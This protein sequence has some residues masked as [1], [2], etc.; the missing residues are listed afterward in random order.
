MKI[1]T[2]W[3][4]NGKSVQIPLCP[5]SFFNDDDLSLTVDW[6]DG[7]SSETITSFSSSDQI[8]DSN[9]TVVANLLKHTYNNGNG[10]K[11]ITITGGYDNKIAFMQTTKQNSS[12]QTFNAIARGTRKFFR[13]I[14]ECNVGTQFYI[15]G[16]GDFRGFTRLQTLG[17]NIESLTSTDP[18]SSISLSTASTATM[19]MDKTFFGCDGLQFFGKFE[20][21]NAT[22]MQFTLCK[23]KR[24][25]KCKAINN[26][27]MEKV[28]SCKGACKEAA[29]SVGLW[30]WFKDTPDKEYVCEDMSGMFE[31]SSFDKGVNG[32]D[33]STVKDV[34]NM[35]KESNFNKPLWKW[36]KGDNVV[37]NVSG[38]F[39]DN[40]SFNRNLDTWDR[41]NVSG[42]LNMF[43]GASGMSESKKPADV[44]V[45][46]TPTPSPS[47]S[48]ATSPT[49]TPSRTP[50]SETP[51]GFST[52]LDVYLDDDFYETLTYNF[53]TSRW[54]GSVLYLRGT[55]GNPMEWQLRRV[56]DNYKLRSSDT[57]SQTNRDDPQGSDF[58]PNWS[59]PAPSVTP[60]ATAS[61]SAPAPTATPTSSLTPG[62]TP[63][64]S[65]PAP[66]ATPTSSLTP[67]PTP[68]QSAPAPTATPTSS[69][70]PGPTPS[71]SAPAPS[72]TPTSSLTPGP[73]ATLTPSVSSSPPNAY[74]FDQIGKVY[75]NNSVA[76][77][78]S[79]N[80][81]TKVLS[82]DTTGNGSSDTTVTATIDTNEKY[83]L[84]SSRDYVAI[85]KTTPSQIFKMKVTEVSYS[86]SSNTTYYKMYNSDYQDY[87][88]GG[89]NASN[90]DSLTATRNIRDYIV[91]ETDSYYTSNPKDYYV[92][93][94]GTL[95]SNILWASAGTYYIRSRISGNYTAISVGDYLEIYIA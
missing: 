66:T 3:I 28:K 82:L 7:T 15:H 34:S 59:I 77:I 93:Y 2:T 33:V 87:T 86:S 81:S 64:Q 21:T 46:A 83:S 94:N 40:T 43:Q 24:L 57:F 38:M 73:T 75:Y 44:Q 47:S 20:P 69:L 50:A 17:E 60:T 27:D 68:S 55:T 84:F 53:S 65:A 79:Y 63:S 89:S 29:I 32:W 91:N 5:S 49:P 58:S 39:Q 37:E 4:K 26:W 12:G 10:H 41:P 85:Y 71:Q 22:S 30:K 88:I 9:G 51:D 78:I 61:Q 35:F 31:G 11:V 25:N 70:T 62:P 45:S 48:P 95:Q 74:F 92:L 67:G 42:E 14:F 23:C 6:G 19:F 90:A 18:S 16:Q 72:A 52:S 54:V 80:A 1:K 76:D 36:F 8:T 56:S 13:A